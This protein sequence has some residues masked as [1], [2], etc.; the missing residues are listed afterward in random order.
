MFSLGPTRLF[1]WI[2][3]SLPPCGLLQAFFFF[4][5]L[6]C[7]SHFQALRAATAWFP[8]HQ[9]QSLITFAQ[10]GEEAPHRSLQVLISEIC[11]QSE[12][13]ERG[14]PSKLKGIMLQ[15]FDCMRRQNPRTGR[16]SSEV[17]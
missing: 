3:G 4:F 8:E 2:A 7:V 17:F 11:S 13:R 10:I 16:K 14:L 15:A 12:E 9:M 1:L 6:N 5:F